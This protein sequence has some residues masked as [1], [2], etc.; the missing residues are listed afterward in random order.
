[1]RI[2]AAGRAEFERLMGAALRPPVN[3]LSKLSLALKL[4]FLHLLAPGQRR[5][6]AEAMVEMAEQELARLK[7]LYRR[8]EAPAG[9]FARWLAHEIEQAEARLSW[10]RT[11]LGES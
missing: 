2:T 4:R 11:L 6:Q 1:M 8:E 10:F 5:I 7:D 9:P 3:D